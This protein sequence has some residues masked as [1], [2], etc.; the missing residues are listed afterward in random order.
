VLVPPLDPPVEV[1]PPVVAEALLLPAPVEVPI[2]PEAEPQ[3]PA[4]P[5]CGT[6]CKPP[7]QG[8]PPGVQV[9]VHGGTT[10][11]WQAAAVSQQTSES[12]RSISPN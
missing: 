7:G 2:V 12:R 6:H 10:G 8:S 9:T 3:R 5:G 1:A 11:S 4:P